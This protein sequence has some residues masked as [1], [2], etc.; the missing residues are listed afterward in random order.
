ML[1]VTKGRNALSLVRGL[2]VST[3]KVANM[4]TLPDRPWKS[5]RLTK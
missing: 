1:E 4:V 3:S 2:V 5:T